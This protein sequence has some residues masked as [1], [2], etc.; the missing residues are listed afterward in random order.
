MLISQARMTVRDD[1]ECLRPPVI[2]FKI[3]GD[4]K[5]GDMG[6]EVDGHLATCILV[7]SGRPET[8]PPAFPFHQADV[9]S[10]AVPITDA[11]SLFVRSLPWRGRR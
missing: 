9:K 5:K 4:L 8:V 11:F 3:E 7:V 10:L 6:A 1:E 2:I